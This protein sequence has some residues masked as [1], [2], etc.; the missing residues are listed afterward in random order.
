MTSQATTPLNLF[1]ALRDDASAVLAQASDGTDGP[2]VGFHEEA[3][4]D[5]LRQLLRRDRLKLF[6]RMTHFV[7]ALHRCGVDVYFAIFGLTPNSARFRD[8]FGTGEAADGVAV[9]ADAVDVEYDAGRFSTS[10]GTMAQLV[11]AINLLSVYLEIDALQRRIHEIGLACTSQEKLDDIARAWTGDFDRYRQERLGSGQSARHFQAI[12]DFLLARFPDGDF[13][14]SDL[15]SA[16]ALQ[17]WCDNALND[18]LDVRLYQSAHEA[19]VD[20]VVAFAEQAAMSGVSGADSL[21]DRE[22]L[23]GADPAHDGVTAH[24]DWAALADD[25]AAIKFLTAKDRKIVGPIADLPLA[26][27]ALLLSAFRAWCFADVQN[28]LVEYRRRGRSPE[29]RQA[30]LDALLEHGPAPSYADASTQLEAAADKLRDAALATSHVLLGNRVIDGVGLLFHCDPELGGL[31][32]LAERVRATAGEDAGPM[33][34]AQFCDELFDAA[35]GDGAPEPTLDAALERARG[36]W[37]KNERAGFRRAQQHDAHVVG[38][39][40]LA[41]QR[42]PGALGHL[43]NRIGAL[44]AELLSAGGPHALQASDTMTVHNQLAEIHG[45]VRQELS[46]A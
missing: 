40:E 1:A 42:L 37:S 28:R 2:A 22:D 45:S 17:F 6:R 43:E 44:E 36:A 32:A 25:F 21:A 19:C 11:C 7:A 27:G 41:S 35:A 20:F 46:Q 15:G 12:A 18:S 34:I 29:A 4:A 31:P 14:A 16:L 9:T 30:L 3:L 26:A 24:E 5:T 23:S 39:L 13:A 33:N 38:E 10:F 8:L